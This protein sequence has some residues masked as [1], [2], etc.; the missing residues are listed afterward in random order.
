MVVNMRNTVSSLIMLS[1]GMVS[2]LCCIFMNYS[3]ESTLIILV[4]VLFVFM[5]IGYIAQKIINNMTQEAEERFRQEE[6]KRREEEAAAEA[7]ALA[8]A[9][10]A[11][12]AEREAAFSAAIGEVQTW[13][14]NDSLS[15]EM[16]FEENVES[17]QE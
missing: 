3:L 6:A 13:D 12:M 7:A 10:A 4:T 1:A 2:V 5:I 16:Y 9:E 14:S 17:I 8:E 11:E 15:N